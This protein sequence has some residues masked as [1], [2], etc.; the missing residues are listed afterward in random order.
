MPAGLPASMLFLVSA[1]GCSRLR[2]GR[3]AN[4]WPPCRLTVGATAR[5][6]GLRLRSRG[7]FRQS[8]LAVLLLKEGEERS[9]A[10]TRHAPNGERDAGPEPGAARS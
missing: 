4:S 10:N 1:S 2:P 5:S 3:D 9:D 8:P 6:I 7:S